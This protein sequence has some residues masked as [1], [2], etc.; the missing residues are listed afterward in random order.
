MEFLPVAITGVTLL[1]K[2]VGVLL[3]IVSPQI[4]ESRYGVDDSQS[5][6]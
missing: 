1:L 4:E 2:K 3:T 6:D 5:I